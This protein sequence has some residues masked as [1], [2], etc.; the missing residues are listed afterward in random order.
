MSFKQQELTSIIPEKADANLE[1]ATENA[2]EANLEESGDLEE[3]AE[4]SAIPDIVPT[5]TEAAITKMESR[6]LRAKQPIANPTCDVDGTD[7]KETPTHR[8][9]GARGPSRCP[10]HKVDGMLD[11]RPASTTSKPKKKKKESQ[12]FLGLSS[13]D[14][15]PRKLPM[16]CQHSKCNAPATYTLPTAVDE[17]PM[18]CSEH[19]KTKKDAYKVP[20]HSSCS[21][22]DD[23]AHV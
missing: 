15:S 9:P 2:T 21:P 13:M 10:Q 23:G 12:P 11:V 17:A 14:P 18:F 3:A 20:I 6:E 8:R 16:K 19:A 1:Q 5:Q 7:C 4:N 22:P